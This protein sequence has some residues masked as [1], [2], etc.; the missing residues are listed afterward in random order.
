[1]PPRPCKTSS[2]RSRRSKRRYSTPKPAARPRFSSNS[3][4]RPLIRFHRAVHSVHH[5]FHDHSVCSHSRQ[6]S[7]YR[8]RRASQHR[9]RITHLANSTDTYSDTS[10]ID[11][12]QPVPSQHP[13]WNERGAPTGDWVQPFTVRSLSYQPRH[14]SVPCLRPNS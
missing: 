5:H 13:G 11:R 2:P 7:L 4:N 9:R 6:D 12:R 14:K 10:T 1:M 8:N 3:S